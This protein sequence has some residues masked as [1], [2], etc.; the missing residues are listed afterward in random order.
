MYSKKIDEILSENKIMPGD[1]VKIEPDGITGEIMPKP[2]SSDSCILV[3]KLKNGYN[4]G[5]EFR[6]ETKIKKIR[7]ADFRFEFSGEGISEVA[8]LP[9]I[10]LI[11][12]GGTIGSKVDY[13]TG[14]VYM[15][16]KPEELLHEVPELSLIANIKVENLFSIA[17]EDMTYTEWQKIAVRISELITNNKDLR[18]I[19]ITHGTDTMHYTA[20]ALSFMLGDVPIPVVLTGSQRS[21]DRGSSDAFMNLVCATHIASKSDI[22]EVGICMH[23][24]SN[25]D[26]CAFIRGTKARKMHTS[27]R[28]AF[29]AVNDKPMALVSQSGDIEITNGYKKRRSIGGQIKPRLEFE[30]KVALV[31]VYPNSDPSIIDFYIEKKYAG[32]IIEGTGLG[33]APVSGSHEELRWTESIKRAIDAGIIVGMTSQCI[34]GRTNPYVY[35]N[36]RILSGLGVVYCEDMTPETAYV[37][38]GWLLGNFKKDE[39]RKMLNQNLAGEIKAR[40]EFEE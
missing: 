6:P 12:T 28:D 39:A 31:K 38:L 33:H 36:L 3:I 2:D 27:R 26:F 9:D 30:G 5:I 29:A 40:T 34:F 22:A 20:S 32:I 19:V 16:I 25:D 8:G 4:I 13:K 1:L 37:K 35:R 17:S 7:G 23:N 15:L 21:S 18:G 14:G 24:S 10:A 11:Y